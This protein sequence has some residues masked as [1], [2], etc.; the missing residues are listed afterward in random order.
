MSLSMICCAAYRH[1]RIEPGLS[2]AHTA[3]RLR[4]GMVMLCQRLGKVNASNGKNI[5]PPLLSERTSKQS[6]GFALSSDRQKK[7]R[8]GRLARHV[9]S[10]VPR[11]RAPNPRTRPPLPRAHGISSRPN[12]LEGS[13]LDTLRSPRS[14]RDRSRV[15]TR[16]VRA[17]VVRATGRFLDCPRAS[18]APGRRQ[19]PEPRGTRAGTRRASRHGGRGPSQDQV[20]GHLRRRYAARFVREPSP[21]DEPRRPR[22]V[23]P[24]FFPFAR[25]LTP[26]ARAASRPVPRRRGGVL[27]LPGR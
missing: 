22:R 6:G 21:R 19:D 2:S 13:S 24:P 4:R 26:S 3:T 17:R 12:A 15:P 23:H 8:R 5:S 11:K 1:A 14:S 9:N 27:D 20:R 18:L 25:S 16:G 7:I 10:A